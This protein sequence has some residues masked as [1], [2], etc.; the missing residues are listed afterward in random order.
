MDY[1]MI[2]NL[3]IRTELRSIKFGEFFSYI[4]Y[5]ILALQGRFFAIMKFDVI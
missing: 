1:R 2:A 3:K 4:F 5:Q